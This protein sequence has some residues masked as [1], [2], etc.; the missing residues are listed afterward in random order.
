MLVPE[1]RVFSPPRRRAATS[2][3]SCHGCAK[4]RSTQSSP[5]PRSSTRSS[6]R[7]A[8]SR[9]G[10]S[11]RSPCTST[12]CATRGSASRPLETPGS[13][14]RP[15]AR[16]TCRSS[17]RETGRGGGAP[18]RLAGPR[19]GRPASTASRRP[20]ARRRHRSLCVPAGSHR[21]EMTYRPPG[22]ALS[23]ATSALALAAA[24]AL[25]RRGGRGRGRG[26]HPRRTALASAPPHPLAAAR[27]RALDRR[28]AP[29][30][31]PPAAWRGGSA[32]CRRG[33]R[34]SP[35]RAFF[36]VPRRA[37]PAGPSG[38]RLRRRPVARP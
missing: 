31:R 11:P 36:P 14:R 1:D 28:R 9:P 30:G 35:Q 15:S 27:P 7:T 4:P 2:T 23:L 38:R 37:S 29:H 33:A 17:S 12:A 13:S 26:G 34:A 21:V 24:A 5:W 25:A 8:P 32:R 16:T 18:A 20:C 3:R 22:L 10:A 19:A 6:R